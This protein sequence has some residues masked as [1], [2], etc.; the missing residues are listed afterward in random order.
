MPELDAQDTLGVGDLG[1]R[2]G[3]PDAP[4]QVVE[5]SDFSCPYC[6]TFHLSTRDSLFATYVGRGEVRWISLPYVSG[7]YA[8]STLA[9]SAAVCAA[10]WGRYDGLARALYRDRG[11]WVSAP[12]SAAR[13]FILE[14]GEGVGLAPGELARCMESDATLDRI[15]RTGRMAQELG[16][17]GTPT[18]FI[19]GFPAM[20]ALPFPYVRRLID[21]RRPDVSPG[22]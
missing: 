6:A 15:R 1:V 22:G 16:V 14:L 11:E 9:T 10:R 20:G 12:A 21:G 3:D 7:L 5:F 18:Y 17:R 13:T 8:N 4:V 19:D 2:H